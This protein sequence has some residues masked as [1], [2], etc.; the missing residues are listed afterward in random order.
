[1]LRTVD[2]GLL[3]L[4]GYEIS[5]GAEAVDQL[6]NPA[7]PLRGCQVLHLN[8]T[9]HGG[10]VAEILRSGTLRASQH[11]TIK[12]RDGGRF[13]Y[14]SDPQNV[15]VVYISTDANPVTGRPLISRSVFRRHHEI[16]R[17]ITEDGGRSWQWTPV[18]ANSPAGNYRPLVPIWPEAGERTLLVWMR[19]S[20]Q[21]NRG[22]WNTA[23]TATLLR[24]SSF[25]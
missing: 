5:A 11:S 24:N 4:A 14:S 15:N 20:Y 18:T 17:G 10:G 2:T 12:L 9:P 3:C 25:D 1:M 7:R 23:V 8:A 6:R 21:V 19:G 22:E 13:E 16:F